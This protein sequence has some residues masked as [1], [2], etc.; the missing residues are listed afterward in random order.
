MSEEPRY[1]SVEALEAALMDAYNLYTSMEK[2]IFGDVE[3]GTDATKEVRKKL[4][5]LVE[6]VQNK[7]DVSISTDYA[8][9]AY[10]SVSSYYGEVYFRYDG[11]NFQV[12]LEDGEDGIDVEIW[13]EMGCP[14]MPE[15][16]S[17]WRYKPA[18]DVAP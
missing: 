12:E 13:A 18:T 9:N 14:K 8:F 2:D 10:L 7:F 16:G 6:K 11:D 3:P 4:D 5:K 1:K 17:Y 15:W